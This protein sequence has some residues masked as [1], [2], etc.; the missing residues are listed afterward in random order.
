MAILDYE[1]LCL[2]K[3]IHGPMFYLKS[4]THVGR[5]L[6]YYGEF[7]VGETEILGTF[8]R[9]DSIIID[10]GANI[11]AH[12]IFFAKKASKGHVIAIEP[13]PQIF[14]ILCA[15]VV[16]NNLRNVQTIH[17]GI[18]GENT[19]MSVPNLDYNQINNYGGVSLQ[20]A[21]QGMHRIPVMTLDGIELPKCDLIKCDVEGMEHQVLLGGMNFLRQH[22]P[23]LYVEN[24]RPQ[25]AVALAQAIFDLGYRIWRHWAPLF[26]EKNFKRRTKDLFEGKVS[27]ALLCLPDGQ[28]PP[29]AGL[30]E[31]LTPQDA[32][33]LFFP[34]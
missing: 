34:T 23:V 31:I 20:A 13:Q 4:D 17:G 21:T 24:D 8:I 25:N 33:R 2:E 15:N 19:L 6:H 30:A 10:I 27:P 5:S 9:P 1:E 12:T 14:Q 32:H 11:G 16:A 28:I 26:R 18:G 22:K 29:N 7:S 3:T